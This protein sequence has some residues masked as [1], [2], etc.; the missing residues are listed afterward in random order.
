MVRKGGLEPP[1][2]SAPPPQ[3]GVS[4]NF[5]TSAHTSGCIGITG[6]KQ[7]RRGLV[8]IAKETSS[9]EVIRRDGIPEPRLILHNFAECR[10]IQTGAADE[11]AVNLNL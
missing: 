6:F 1:C 8:S 3:D 2:L 7:K 11:R 4:A 9:A 10:R 5:T